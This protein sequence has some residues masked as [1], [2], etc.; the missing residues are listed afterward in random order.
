MTA[1]DDLIRIDGV[2]YTHESGPSQ[3]VLNRKEFA[4]VLV[5][6]KRKQ[7]HEERIAVL[8]DCYDRLAF[9]AAETIIDLQKLR[10]KI[11]GKVVE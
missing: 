9:E 5:S 1:N 3:A 4:V 11:D 2:E 7:T 6:P 8:E 10:H